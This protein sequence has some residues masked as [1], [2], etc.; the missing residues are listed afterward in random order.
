MTCKDIKF[1]KEISFN[2]ELIDEDIKLQE[3]CLY[4]YKATYDDLFVLVEDAY[5]RLEIVREEKVVLE[6][7]MFYEE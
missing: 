7:L 6:G 1:A 2:A 3:N 5:T 4:E